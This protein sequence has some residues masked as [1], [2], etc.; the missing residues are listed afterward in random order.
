MADCNKPKHDEKKRPDRSS[1]RNKKDK[2]IYRKGKIEK[3]MVAKENKSAWSDSD[4]DESGSE[5]SSSSDS[6]DEV[7]CL[8]ADDTEEVFDFSNLEFTREDLVTAPNEMVLEYKKLSQSFTELKL[9]KRV[10]QQALS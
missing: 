8:M 10:V 9:K 4:S 2:K 3:A 6:E 7:Q 1:S 5:D